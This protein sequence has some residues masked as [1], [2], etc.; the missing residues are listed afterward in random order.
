L[1][2]AAKPDPTAFG[3]EGNTPAVILDQKHSRGMPPRAL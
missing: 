1:G 3:R 2:P